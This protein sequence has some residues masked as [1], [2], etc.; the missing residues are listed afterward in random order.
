MSV[1]DLIVDIETLS[2]EELLCKLVAVGMDKDIAGDYLAII[3]QARNE[4]DIE[5]IRKTV[6]SIGRNWPKFIK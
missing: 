3:W 5:K 6:E 2:A 1:D 4:K